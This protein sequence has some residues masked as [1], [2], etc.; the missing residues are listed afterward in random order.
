VRLLIEAGAIISTA[1]ATG[2]TALKMARKYVTIKSRHCW[3]QLLEL[4][5]LGI[6]LLRGLGNRGRTAQNQQ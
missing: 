1:D 5:C 6:D 4:K 2:M 3:R